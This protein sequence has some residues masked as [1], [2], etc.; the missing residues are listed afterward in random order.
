MN[1]NHEFEARLRTLANGT[2][3]VE[4]QCI[5]C[6]QSYSNG[7]K[8]KDFNLNELRPYDDNLKEVYYENYLKDKEHREQ[9][10]RAVFFEKYDKYLQSNE[11]KMKRDFV[12]KRDNYTCQACLSRRAEDVHHLTYRHVFNEPLFDLVSVCRLC[13]EKITQMERE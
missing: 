2:K 11:W 1:C 6:G 9:N 12:F 10:N 4:M 7:I 8:K 3:R 5:I 13:H